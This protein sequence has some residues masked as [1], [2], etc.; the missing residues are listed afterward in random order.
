MNVLPMEKQ[1]Q[2]VSAL[3]EGSSIRAI[4]RM[5]GIHRDTIMRLGVKIGEGCSYLL[6]EMMVNLPCQRVQIDEIWG[7]IGKKQKNITQRETQE[8]PDLG[9][10]WTYVAVDADTKLV[11]CYFVGKRN[12]PN[13]Q[14]FL[15]D[16][17][18]RMQNKI[19]L[20]SDSL[21]HYTMTVEYAFGTNV[22]YGQIVKVYGSAQNLQGKYS[23]P[24]LVAAEKRITVG[25]P[26]ER[27]ISTSFVE[28]QN[29]TMR[30]HCRRLTRLT[31]AFSKKLDN[32]KAAIGLHF[33]YY[34]LVK[35]HSTL[36]ATPCMASGLTK[37]PWTVAEL[38][39]RVK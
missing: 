11:P 32:F 20:S 35:T 12:L 39:E 22:D 21:T 14:A 17:A 26:D 13:S 30:M 1:I 8:R 29:L 16:L 9:E 3:A 27:H 36:R 28:S 19:Q 15:D 31:N 6:Q 38:I 5:T 4:E 10:M 2:V 18:N 23:P 25:K 7:F 33:G 24:K 34:N 37:S